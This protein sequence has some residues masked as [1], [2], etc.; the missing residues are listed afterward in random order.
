MTF[1][2]FVTVAI[3]IRRLDNNEWLLTGSLTKPL[4]N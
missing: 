1:D 2:N 4:L 3:T